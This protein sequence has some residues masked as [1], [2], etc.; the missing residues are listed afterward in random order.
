ME[1]KKL[2]KGTLSLKEVKYDY[3]YLKTVMRSGH[4][5]KI[6]LPKHLIGKEIY[7]IIPKE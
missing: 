5:G 2:G 7:I 3:G 4:V 1:N 6:Y